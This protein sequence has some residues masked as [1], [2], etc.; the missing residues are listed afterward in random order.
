MLEMSVALARMPLER[1]VARL[2]HLGVG[3]ALLRPALMRPRHA[4]E[5]RTAVAAEEPGLVLLPAL[6]A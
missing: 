6:I 2:A 4:L 5:A 1:L 3:R